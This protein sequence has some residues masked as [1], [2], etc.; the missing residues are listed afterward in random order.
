MHRCLICKLIAACG[1]QPWSSVTSLELE[2]HVDDVSSLHIVV[3]DGLFIGQRLASVDQT[4]H[5]NVNSFL[6]LQG[7]LDVQDGVRRLEV[8]RLLHASQSLRI[9]DSPSYSTQ[10][11]LRNDQ[12]VEDGSKRLTLMSKCIFDCSL[13]KL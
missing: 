5:W 3:G 6:L 9:Q 13:G 7:L 2:E 11:F 10:A 4:N 1:C 8:E 12:D